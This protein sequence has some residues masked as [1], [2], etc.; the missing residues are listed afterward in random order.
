MVFQMA[1]K[2]NAREKFIEFLKKHPEMSWTE[3]GEK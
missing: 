2:N 3:S 1:G